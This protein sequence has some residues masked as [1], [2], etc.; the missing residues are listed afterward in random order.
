MKKLLIFS[1]LIF[2]LNIAANAQEDFIPDS[3]LLEM[4]LTKSACFGKCPAY[5]LSIYKNKVAIYKGFSNVDKE[6]IYMKKLSGAE[7]KKVCKAFKNSDFAS[8]KNDFFDHT[9]ADAPVTTL[10]YMV[11]KEKKTIQKNLT[12][13]EVLDDLE[14]KMGDLGNSSG[15]VL[16][17]ELENNHGGGVPR[18]SI[19]N[20]LIVTL[21]KDTNAEKWVT[22]YDEYD[23]K[24]KK[25][26][27]PRYN[28]WVVEYDLSKVDGKVFLNMMKNDQEV[29]TAEFNAKVS[30]RK[31]NRSQDQ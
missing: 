1:A 11:N 9:I 7:Y 19:E 2:S 8:I 12:W 16:K 25:K 27:S 28:I 15:W 14:L 24:L 29:K 10:S 13:S 20:E 5:K 21:N 6:G 26:I 18:N 31:V 3:D 22:A 4:E 30:P 23:L 17:K